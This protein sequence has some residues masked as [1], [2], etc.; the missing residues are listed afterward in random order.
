MQRFAAMLDRKL[1]PIKTSL[2][3][4]KK[5]LHQV[6]SFSAILVE[7][8]AG[9]AL[10]DREQQKQ[11]AASVVLKDA[12]SV[13]KCVLP[14]GLPPHVHEVAAGKLAAWLVEEVGR[15]LELVGGAQGISMLPHLSAERGYWRACDACPRGMYG[16]PMAA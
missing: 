6:E 11:E 10:R 1:N 15:D 4:M 7:A 5:S 14:P 8:V 3:E 16:C 2:Q 12:A 13:V 9:R